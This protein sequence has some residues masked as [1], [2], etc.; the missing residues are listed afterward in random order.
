MEQ[1][2]KKHAKERDGWTDTT[3]LLT[4]RKSMTEKRWAGEEK[5]ERDVR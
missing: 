2:E 1:C 3:F 4:Q 5:R